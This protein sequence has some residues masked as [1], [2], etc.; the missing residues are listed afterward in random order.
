LRL[1]TALSR[2]LVICAKK[3]R[4]F[5]APSRPAGYQKGQNPGVLVTRVD[6][7]VVVDIL[8]FDQFAKEQNQV[9]HIAHLPICIDA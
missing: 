4:V 6:L 5:S 3:N 9:A 2:R 1:V 7:N 8:E